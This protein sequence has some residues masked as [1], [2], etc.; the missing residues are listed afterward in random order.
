MTRNMDI[1]L[2]KVNTVKDWLETHAED[3]P[4]WKENYF[5]SRLDDVL[6]IVG[7][8]DRRQTERRTR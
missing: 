2:G 3:C 1:V 8:K 4:T 5:I 7:A 6:Q